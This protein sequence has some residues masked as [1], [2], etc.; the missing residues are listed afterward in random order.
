[1]FNLEDDKIADTADLEL[2]RA[3]GAPMVDA[4]GNRCSITIYGPGSKQ[5][6][7]AKA[8]SKR[9]I[10]RKLEAAGGNVYAVEDNEEDD[11]HFLATIT[12]SFNNFEYPE[13]K[14]EK[15]STKNDMFKACYSDPKRAYIRT[16]VENFY[17]EWGNFAKG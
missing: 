2:K 1:M 9:R 13:P 16:Q 7:T 6:V 14:G 12:A 3:N 10:R 5:Q 11:L 4:D 15:F 8:E 17:G